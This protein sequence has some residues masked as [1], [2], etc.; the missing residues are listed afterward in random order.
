M[1]F[2]IYPCI[3]FPPKLV[4]LESVACNQVALTDSETNAAL[5]LW[6]ESLLTSS[7]SASPP[8][9]TIPHMTN[10]SLPSKAILVPFWEALIAKK[11]IFMLHG[12]LSSLESPPNG[13]H[14]LFFLSLLKKTKIWGGASLVAQWLRICLPMQGTRVRSLVWEDPT[15]H[16]AATPVSHNC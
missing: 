15:C 5:A 9:A 14:S 6:L 12:N 13:P 2:T 10:R 7:P 4:R 1:N 8:S 16:G 11:C 3:L